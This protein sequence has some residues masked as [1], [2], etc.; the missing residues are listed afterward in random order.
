MLI[1][2]LFFGT[3]KLGLEHSQFIASLM[4]MGLGLGLNFF[5]WL[6]VFVFRKNLLQDQRML[7]SGGEGITFF[8][9][10]FTTFLCF[11]QTKSD[12]LWHHES[13]ACLS[14]PG[15]RKLG[16]W[17]IL[18]SMNFEAF[19]LITFSGS[20]SRVWDSCGRCKSFKENGATNLWL[21]DV[22][23]REKHLKNRNL[24]IY[25]HLYCEIVMWFI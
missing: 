22:I 6:T 5:C 9:T 20:S 17:G 19:I 21:G 7:Q 1:S 14:G 11:R 3:S 24:S 8:S 4:V 25:H 2:T 15:P 12:V 10:H 18:Y 13:S 16:H 23:H